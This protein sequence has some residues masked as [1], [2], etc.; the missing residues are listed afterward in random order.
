MRF[1]GDYGNEGQDSME[2]D[3]IVHTNQ[4]IFLMTQEVK[5]GE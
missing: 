2:K 4:F 1:Y 5:T 3:G